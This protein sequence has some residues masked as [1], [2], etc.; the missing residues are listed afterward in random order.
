MFAKLDFMSAVR[1]NNPEAIQA[2]SLKNVSLDQMKMALRMMQDNNPDWQVRNAGDVTRAII[3]GI[4]NTI[5][6]E[7]EQRSAAS[8]PSKTI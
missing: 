3:V 8:A 5:A 2:A 6:R 4:T 7:E 1:L